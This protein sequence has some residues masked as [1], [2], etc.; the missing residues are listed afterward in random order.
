ALSLAHRVQDAI[1]MPVAVDGVE[2]R[3]SASVGIAL[4]HADAEALLGDADAAVYRAKAVP[5]GRVEVAR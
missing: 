5:G 2:H 4:G 3:L 1:Q